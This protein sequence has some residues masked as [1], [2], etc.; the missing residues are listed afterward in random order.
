MSL[1]IPCTCRHLSLEYYDEAS[2]PDDLY[3][4]IHRVVHSK[5]PRTLRYAC[6]EWCGGVCTAAGMVSE[7]AR[8]RPARRSHDRKTRSMAQ[9]HSTNIRETGLADRVRGVQTLLQLAAVSG[10]QLVIDGSLFTKAALPATP[11]PDRLYPKVRVQASAC[12]QFGSVSGLG[13]VSGLYGC[14]TAA[15][16]GIFPPR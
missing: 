15:G 12:S 6:R 10:R 16:N 8:G 1:G 4:A 14:G 11:S 13:R 7:L 3:N 2:L 5:R 9:S